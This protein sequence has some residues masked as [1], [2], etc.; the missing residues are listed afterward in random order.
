MV[1]NVDLFILFVH[2]NQV[3]DYV[4][5]VL[6]GLNKELRICRNT[7]LAI[8]MVS[9]L[10]K[11]VLKQK[12]DF[13]VSVPDDII[14]FLAFDNLFI[15]EYINLGSTCKRI[16]N[17]LWDSKKNGFFHFA[18]A[19]WKYLMSF[20]NHQY[21]HLVPL[22]LIFED[23]IGTNCSANI[24]WFHIACMFN[25]YINGV[26][27]KPY[28]M[29]ISPGK[30][31][32][33]WG[34]TVDNN[35]IMA[36]Y[37]CENSCILA[38]KYSEDR[39]HYMGFIRNE[40]AHG[41][42][43]WIAPNAVSGG[44]DVIEEGTF[45]C[46]KFCNGSLSI[47]DVKVNGTFEIIKDGR[48]IYIFKFGTLPS[49]SIDI[50]SITTVNSSEKE[51]ILILK[52]VDKQIYNA[53]NDKLD[54]C[55]NLSKQEYPQHLYYV[56]YSKT[57]CIYCLEN[58]LSPSDSQF[59]DTKVLLEWNNACTCACQSRALGESRSKLRLKRRLEVH[60]EISSKRPRIKYTKSDTKV[61]PDADDASSDD[62]EGGTSSDE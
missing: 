1:L 32:T 43:V 35:T 6:D 3:V 59:Q 17:I 62:I 60:E 7:S 8:N 26:I 58:C 37:F 55:K 14:F 34:I 2:M 15:N 46:G 22:E 11:I 36:G 12:S 33:G 19:M 42:G 9:E 54:K 39:I 25:R 52:N 10:S 28:K 21:I 47:G 24:S 49:V 53:R 27:A 5:E 45:S 30:F 61:L 20:F 41:P 29:G 56:G 4:V 51:K 18:T 57:L 44:P 50:P 38:N 31:S 23:M 40:K 13:F 48:N 16:R